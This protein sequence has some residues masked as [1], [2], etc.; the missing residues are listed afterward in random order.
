MENWYH[1]NIMMLEDQDD[2]KRFQSENIEGDWLV[3]TVPATD[4]AHP[5][6][7]LPSVMFIRNLLTKKTYTFSMF[8]PDSR[9]K[10]PPAN[11][12]YYPNFDGF[13]GSNQIFDKCLGRVWA[14]D[15]KAF[16]QLSE[17]PNFPYIYDANLCSYLEKNEMFEMSEYETPA[18]VAIRRRCEDKSIVS[19]AIPILK[20]KEAFDDMA[21]DV[22]R[23]IRRAKVDSAFEH[24]NDLI[25]ILGD[26][27][28]QGICVDPG[29]FKK[30]FD[31]D[32]SDLV[33]SHYNFY[34]STGRPS[35]SFGG[36]N[37]AALKHEDGSRSCFVSRHG[38]NGR[39]VVVDYS[40]FHPRIICNLTNHPI[41]GDVDI[42]EYLAKLYYQKKEVDETDISNAKKLTFRQLYGGL[43]DKYSHIKYLANLKSYI[44]AQWEFFKKNNYVETPIF[45]RKIT[46]SH[47][48]DPNPTKVFN[49]LLQAVEG[50]VAIP[51][52]KSVLKYLKN[53]H[54]KVMLYT[55]DAVLYD[56]HKDDGI[57]TLNNIRQLM[58]CQGMFP[59]KTYIGKSYNDVKLVEI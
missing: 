40:A 56:F 5:A 42:Y 33:Y 39:M 4:N 8:H 49:Y 31:V 41:D 34:T 24:F 22:S 3:H 47:I 27:E 29:L 23:F 58:S 26:V 14:L 55:Y 32:S 12:M 6:C 28:K 44:D 21:D 11:A 43:E 20:H 1:P 35:N 38:D 16:K 10:P 15:S 18:H 46:D 13:I 52:L 54:T 2:L 9:S 48:K 50:E 19:A 36:V 37:Y 53:K 30:H 59:M 51:P 25:H 57:E 45:K 7:N 17:M